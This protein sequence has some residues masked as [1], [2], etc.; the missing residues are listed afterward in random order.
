MPSVI[1]DFTIW[2]CQFIG[3]S[4]ILLLVVHVLAHRWRKR[5]LKEQPH[6]PAAGGM[7]G[8]PIQRDRGN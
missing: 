5:R 1:H 8:Q 3:A 4:V 2:F 6:P 7:R